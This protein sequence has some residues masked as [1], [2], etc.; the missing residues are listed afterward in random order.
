MEYGSPSFIAAVTVGVILTKAIPWRR[1]WYGAFYLIGRTAALLVMAHR[2]AR[3]DG[4]RRD[5]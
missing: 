1:I 3:D 5:R 4:R 2:A